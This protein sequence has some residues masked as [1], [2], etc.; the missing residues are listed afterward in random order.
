MTIFCSFSISFLSYGLFLWNYPTCNLL[1]F[2]R[3][4]DPVI[5]RNISISDHA[6]AYGGQHMNV[7][8]VIGVDFQGVAVQH[9]KIRELAGFQGAGI[10]FHAELIRRIDGVGLQGLLGRDVWSASSHLHFVY[11][12]K[13]RLKNSRNARPSGPLVGLST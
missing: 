10:L 5:F 11:L 7:S 12:G 6:A 8:D 1:L 3:R 4:I 9:D 13:S 2:T